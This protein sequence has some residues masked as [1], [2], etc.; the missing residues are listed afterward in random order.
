MKINILWFGIKSRRCE[1]QM[2]IC[3]W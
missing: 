3:N 1:Y 2:Y